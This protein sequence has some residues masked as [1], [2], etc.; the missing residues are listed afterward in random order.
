MVLEKKSNLRKVEFTFTD[1]KI[2][3]ECI[4]EYNIIIMDDSKQIAQSKHR[5]VKNIEEGKKYLL[6][7]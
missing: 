4:C 1:G 6:E 7:L 3:P 2:H 5:E